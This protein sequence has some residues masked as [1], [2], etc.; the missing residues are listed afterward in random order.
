MLFIKQHRIDIAF[1]IFIAL[2]SVYYGFYSPAASTAENAYLA[3]ARSWL[4]SGNLPDASVPP[5]VPWMIAGIWNFTGENFFI[6]KMLGLVFLEAAGIILY[7][8]IRRYKGGLFSFGAAALAMLNVYMLSQ[9]G[10]IYADGLSLFFLVAMLCFLKSETP[11]HWFLSGI[12]LGLALA[13]QY[14]VG[15]QALAVFAA[16]SIARRKEKLAT[17]TVL[18]ALPVIASVLY[19][20]ISR[21]GTFKIGLGSIAMN[22]FPTPSSLLAYFM[23]SADIWGFVF[24]L[25]PLAFLFRRTYVDKYNYAF[26]AWLFSSLLLAA[27]FGSGRS[28]IIQATPAVYFLVMLGLENIVKHKLLVDG[29]LLKDFL[30]G[31]FSLTV[32]VAF[33]YLYFS[34]FGIF[35]N[36]LHPSANADTGRFSNGNGNANYSF[37][38]GYLLY[39][40][41]D[42]VLDGV[43]SSRKFIMPTKKVIIIRMDD[44]QA[45]AWNK[46]S[47]NITDTVL[48][49]NMSITLGVIPKNIDKD[50][51]MKNY[52][53]G[54]LNNPGVE[55]A[56]H[57]LNH[58]ESEF[59]DLNESY[60]YEL[61]K[62]G[63]EKLVKTFGL[64]PVTFIPPNNEY[65]D[66]TAKALS[67][68]GFKVLS[69][70]YEEYRFDGNIAYIGYTKATKYSKKYELTPVNEVLDS[71]R[72]S[73]QLRNVCVIL[74]HPQ[75]FASDDKATMSD[76]RYKKFVELLDGLKTM[77]ATFVNFKELVE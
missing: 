32:I 14:L 65:S 67:K 40:D 55:I 74:L 30:S 58:S 18:G 39:S 61:A 36:P 19:L 29:K 31:I 60:A 15:L 42:S 3:N 47:P 22:I 45:W 27:A 38:S 26:I 6:L 66:D 72:V 64:Y 17:R 9:S 20:V 11:K 34:S 63:L 71:C 51:M 77:N 54:R 76:D 53:A 8:I 16:E 37:P 44:V 24:L 50:P 57:G 75:D 43:N 10:Q 1:T 41:S 35:S 12:M 5:L 46:I 52:L 68:L 23:K 69:A 28:I 33:A 25:L 13:T 4:S 2:L 21:T 49:K 62:A 7:I 56:Q 73:L 59:R 48:G 70:E